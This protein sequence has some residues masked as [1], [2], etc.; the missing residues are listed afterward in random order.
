MED[1]GGG[2]VRVTVNKKRETSSG[3]GFEDVVNPIEELADLDIDPRVTR[4]RTSLTP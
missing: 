2:R 4:F 1:A 3:V